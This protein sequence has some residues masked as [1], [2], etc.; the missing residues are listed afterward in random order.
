MQSLR[1]LSRGATERPV[2][3]SVHKTVACFLLKSTGGRVSQNPLHETA[4]NIHLHLFQCS[5]AKPEEKKRQI[6][7]RKKGTNAVCWQLSRF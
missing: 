3:F 6:K 7:T 4:T 5:L 1:N 2:D